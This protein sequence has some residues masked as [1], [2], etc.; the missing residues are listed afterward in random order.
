MEQRKVAE[1][2]PVELSKELS[3]VPVILRI[4]KEGED[5]RLLQLLE[6]G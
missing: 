1:T 5:N 2:L 3:T 4:A 6:T